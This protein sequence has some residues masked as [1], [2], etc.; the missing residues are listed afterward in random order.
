[1]HPAMA[2]STLHLSLV[3]SSKNDRLQPL[4]IKIPASLGA[5]AVLGRRNGLLRAAWAAAVS[6]PVPGAAGVTGDMTL[7]A[8]PHARDNTSACLRFVRLVSKHVSA[9]QRG[10][11]SWG[12]T[13]SQ[14]HATGE[15]SRAVS[16]Y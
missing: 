12:S 13:A 1:M 6:S 7:S 10:H 5:L 15:H 2:D 16:A 14:V 9:G 4:E 8:A 3:P 11:R